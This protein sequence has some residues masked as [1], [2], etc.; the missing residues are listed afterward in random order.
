[1]ASTTTSHE[2]AQIYLNPELTCFQG[3]AQASM[4]L[5]KH[6]PTHGPHPTHTPG[7]V[8]LRRQRLV[9]LPKDVGQ[10]PVCPVTRVRVQHA[11]ELTDGDGLGVD[12]V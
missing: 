6:P 10:Q 3:C 11:I 1:M 7:L 4:V 12:G 2:R 9:D 8:S 5:C